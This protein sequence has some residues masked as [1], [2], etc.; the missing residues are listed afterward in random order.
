MGIRLGRNQSSSRSF[1][2]SG[3]LKVHAVGLESKHETHQ[4]LLNSSRENTH[5]LLGWMM[6]HEKGD[7]ARNG[8]LPV[9][10][11]EEEEEWWARSERCG[12]GIIGGDWGI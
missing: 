3:A 2:L 6:F 7:R 9:K 4:R 10:C 1:R 5:E 8:L 12:D 11:V